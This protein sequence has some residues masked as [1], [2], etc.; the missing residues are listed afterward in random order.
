[1]LS[2][3][4]IIFSWA[5]VTDGSQITVSPMNQEKERLRKFLGESGEPCALRVCLRE[6]VIWSMREDFP[7]TTASTYGHM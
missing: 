2:E 1:M 5:D 3:S 4:A 7:S 6:K